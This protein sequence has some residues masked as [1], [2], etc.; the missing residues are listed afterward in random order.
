[1]A[2]L[3]VEDGLALGRRPRGSRRAGGRRASRSG[4]PPTRAGPRDGGGRGSSS[5][6]TSR[7]RRPGSPARRWSG[8][9]PSRCGSIPRSIGLTF[10]WGAP[11]SPPPA[12]VDLQASRRGPGRRRRPPR[13]ARPS[14]TGRS[15]AGRWRR[16]W[17]APGARSP[18]ASPPWGVGAGARPGRSPRSGGTGRGT[19]RSG[20]CRPGRC[21]SPASCSTS[22]TDGAST[23]SGTPFIHTPWVL[24]CW[25]V[26]MV[27][28]DGM[29]T[30]DWGWAR[31]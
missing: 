24:G 31:S 9:P 5:S 10:T 29:H 15:G 7:R 13:G 30:T 25:P 12:G 14:A 28:R 1:M 27:E 19:A 3:P 22:A 18:G 26:R 16:G 21:G 2:G 6:R 11:V 23:G 8:R 20:P 17:P 4:P